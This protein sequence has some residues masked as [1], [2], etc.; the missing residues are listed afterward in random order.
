MDPFLGEIRLTAIPF[1]P[2]GWALCQ[3]QLLAIAQ[4]SALF[5]LL[6]NQYGGDGRSAFALP[7][8]AGRI[9]L[10]AGQG[11]GLGSYIQGQQ[12]GTPTVFLTTAQLAGHTHGL[13]AVTTSGTTSVP[14]ASVVLAEGGGK[15]EGKPYYVPSFGSGVHMM[16]SGASGGGAAHNNMSSYLTLN[17]MIALQGIFPT[18]P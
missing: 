2:R 1:A 6:G 3:G 15:G 17:Y 8:L 14:G 16:N 7:N 13:P 5:S 10:H 9:A 4:N 18:R 11:P 12:G